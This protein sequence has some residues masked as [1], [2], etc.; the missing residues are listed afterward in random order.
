MH[1]IAALLTTMAGAAAALTFNGTGQLMA[2]SSTIGDN[3]ALGCMTDVG[4]W[5]IN[6][7]DCGTFEGTRDADSIYFT[8]SSLEGPCELDDSVFTCSSDVT[9]TS[10]WVRADSPCDSSVVHYTDC[11]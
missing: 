10:F 2:Y 7:T 1:A 9:A 8:I 3:S 11:C 4:L 6:G 5:S